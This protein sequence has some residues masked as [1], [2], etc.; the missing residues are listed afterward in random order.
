MFDN[1]DEVQKSALHPRLGAMGVHKGHRIVHHRGVMVCVQRGDYS[2]WVN[3]KLRSDCP[4]NPSKLGMEVL[5]RMAN[6]E[7][8]WPG[9]EW[10]LSVDL[11]PPNGMVVA[12]I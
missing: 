9:Q 3:R 2:M 11:A 4:G 7:P 5:K 1:G 6:R 8:P 12:G 10:P